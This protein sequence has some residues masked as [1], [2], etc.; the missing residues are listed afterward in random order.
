MTGSNA[1]RLRFFWSFLVVLLSLVWVGCSESLRAP[2]AEITLGETSVAV[3]AQVTLDGSGSIDADGRPLAYQWRLSAVPAGSHATIADPG[4]TKTWVLA[5]VAGDYTVELL[6][7]DGVLTSKPATASFT[8]GP[9]GANA[10]RVA[11]ITANPGEPWAGQ[12]VLL[13]ATVTDADTQCGQKESFSYAWSLVDLP[14]GSRAS[15]NDEGLSE[16]SLLTDVPGT[17]R[18]ALVVK[19]SAGNA[20][21]AFETSLTATGCVT[22]PGDVTAVTSTP[23]NPGT[24]EFVTL[25]ASIT[26]RVSTGSS[27]TINDAGIPGDG[28]ATGDAALAPASTGGSGSST[29]EICASPHYTYHW[30]IVSEPA[31]SVAQLN[32]TGL[33]SPSFLPDVP[34]DYAFE[35]YTTNDAG[36]SGAIGRTTITVGDCGTHAPVVASLTA[37]PGAPAIGQAVLLSSVVT[38]ADNGAPCNRTEQLTYRWVLS[39]VPAG[40]AAKLNDPSLAEPSFRPDL[41]GTYEVSLTVVDGEGH[42]S[43]PVATTVVANACGSN[44]PVVTAVTASPSAPH[45]F[46]TVVLNAAVWDADTAAPCNLIENLSLRWALTAVPAGSVAALSGATQTS[47]WFIPDVPGVYTVAVQ[48]VD[49]A[50]HE[51]APRTLQ[52]VASVCGSA[53]PTISSIGIAPAQPHVGSGVS[54]SA[55]VQDADTSCGVTESFTYSWSFAAVPAGSVATLTSPTSATTGFVPDVAGTYTVRLVVTDSEGHS[56]SPA[57]ASVTVAAASTCGTQTPVALLAS[58]TAGPCIDPANCST[59]TI[60]PSIA[61]GPRRIPP[62]YSIQLNGHGSVQL[63]GSKSFDP[64]N[65]SPC[66]AGQPLS[67]LWSL[68]VAPLGSQATWSIGSGSTTSMVAPTFNPDL[69]GIYEVELIVS[70]G[71]HTSTPLIIQIQL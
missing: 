48:A 51:S 62:N 11:S 6:V 65:L 3:G 67:Y 38:D 33:E 36:V 45:T 61:S 42:V 39:A 56:S 63:D 29:Q 52:V 35:V 34:G 47:P 68:L 31:G 21:S 7:S 25:S 2:A 1:M 22:P 49:S 37:S 20:S 54:L 40:S 60:T 69:L 58:F 30:S 46:Q 18:I 53:A 23:A 71:T 5:D 66:F 16:P 14:P 12:A 10:P 24:A 50:G 70:D 32:S 13:S 64:D 44:A 28:A 59:A 43:Q 55:V 19:D 26:P 27:T 15:L 41:A 4:A 8:A 17:Y 9:C 57:Q